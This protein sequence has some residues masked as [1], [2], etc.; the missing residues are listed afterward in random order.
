MLSEILLNQHLKK[1]WG[2]IYKIFIYSLSFAL[3]MSE[4]RLPIDVTKPEEIV[5]KEFYLMVQ[6]YDAKERMAER[7]ADVSPLRK[8]RRGVRD[9]VTR[10]RGKEVHDFFDYD[11]SMMEVT[12]RQP[13]SLG[14]YLWPTVDSITY[15]DGTPVGQSIPSEKVFLSYVFTPETTSLNNGDG[16]SM[17]G[18]AREF[19]LHDNSVGDPLEQQVTV[20]YKKTPTEKSS[21][22]GKIICL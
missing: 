13:H 15:E 22:D 4:K 9:L 6:G 18:E 5:G 20:H 3:L 10:L 7:L 19:R 17:S 1:I 8:L 14:G 2:E 12:D 16:F 11:G 21:G